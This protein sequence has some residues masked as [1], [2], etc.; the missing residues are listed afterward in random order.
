MSS[1]IFKIT[2]TTEKLETKDRSPIRN[3]TCAY[4]N[5]SNSH[6]DRKILERLLQ[7]TTEKY[8]IKLKFYTQTNCESRVKKQTHFGQSLKEFATHRYCSK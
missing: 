4:S 3:D 7:N 2:C 8:L 5:N 1:L 6:R